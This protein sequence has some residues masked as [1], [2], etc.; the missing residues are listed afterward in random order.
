MGCKKAAIGER[1]VGGNMRGWLAA[2]LVA[3]LYTASISGV[4]TGSAAA[5]DY[6]ARTITV[7]VPFPAGGA[8]DSLARFIGERLR[9][10]LG[11]P[12]VIENVAGAAGS[13]GVGR[14][15]R[16]GADGY[17][18]SIGTSTTHMLTGGLYKLPFDVL[19]D[20]EPVI[21]IGSEPLLIVGRSD[22]PADNLKQLITWL[23][24]NSDKAS[25]GIAGVGATGHLTGIASRRG[26]ARRFS[27]CPIA[28]MAR[29]CRTSWRARS[30]R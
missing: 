29:R 2:W 27:S 21:L 9:A 13:L 5:E 17:T 14:A 30:M 4:L 15:V 28:A 6:S 11:Q 19:R 24:A 8:T 12:V 23:K 10:V 3:A 18:L 7:I 1:V 20:L 25:I 26:P 22:L 16:T